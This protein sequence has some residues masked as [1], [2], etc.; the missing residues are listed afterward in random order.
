MI[1][2]IKAARRL[3]R[4]L[5]NI[6]DKD[7][8]LSRIA[9]VLERLGLSRAN[10]HPVKQVFRE[11]GKILRDLEVPPD[12]TAWVREFMNEE[13]SVKP[14]EVE[15]TEAALKRV[16]KERDTLK[17]EVLKLAARNGNLESDKV[18][19]DFQIEALNKEVAA[20]RESQKVSDSALLDDLRRYCTAVIDPSS[21]T[22]AERVALF[23]LLLKR[24][25]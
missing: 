18:A 23:Q 21:A 12:I 17:E 7:P 15:A 10:E 6:Q 8:E 20:L 25:S 11:A 13:S 5:A 19:R 24:V 1:D 4:L 14:A 2:Y 9:D 16:L 22:A 3:R